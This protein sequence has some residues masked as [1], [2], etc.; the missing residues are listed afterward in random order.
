MSFHT[1]EPLQTETFTHRS[2]RTED[3]LHTNAV[4]HE[5][6]ETKERLHQDTFLHTEAF[7]QKS[8]YTQQHT[9]DRLHTYTLTQICK[10]SHSGAFYTQKLL[11][12]RAFTHKR[13]D[14]EELL[15][16]RAFTKK[17][18][19]SEKSKSQYY[20]SFCISN[21]I[22]CVRVVFRNPIFG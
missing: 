18:F 20:L 5:I 17:S 2:I 13:L 22:A 9:K 16:R 6:L 21:L 7:T 4:T 12:R 1:E 11:L 19:Y 3:L 14:T 15:H 8:V 10:S